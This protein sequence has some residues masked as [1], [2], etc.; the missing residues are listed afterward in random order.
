LPFI[1]ARRIAQNE[2]MIQR[3]LLQKRNDERPHNPPPS[4]PSSS[5]S[6]SPSPSPTPTPTPTDSSSPPPN[7]TKTDVSS[8]PPLSAH[9]PQESS[10][11]RFN[12]HLVVILV[13]AIGGAI[14]I[15]IIGVYLCKS[16][17]VATVRPWATGI[18]GQLQKAFVTGMSSY[19]L[20]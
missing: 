19:S 15:S 18:S 1:F 12:I 6:P 13:G 8:P 11:S 4:S 17:K 9:S 7:S 5:P 14:L 20:G 3:R 10:S 2:V 16:N